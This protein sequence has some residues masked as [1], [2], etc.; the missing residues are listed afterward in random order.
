MFTSRTVRALGVLVGLSFVIPAVALDPPVVA[1]ARSCTGWQSTLLPPDTIRVFRKATGVVEVVPFKEYVVTVTAKEWPGWLPDAVIEAG[2]VA[3]K[4]YAW[5]HAMEGRHRGHNVTKSGECFDVR[6]TTADQLYKPAKAR[7]VQRHYAAVDKTWDMT[8]RKQ[9]KQFMTGYRTGRKGDCANDA[10]GWKLFARSA[11]KCANIEG[12]DW[13]R[14]LQAYYSPELQFVRSDGTIVDVD[15]FAI[16]HAAVIG[17]TLTANGRT[18]IFDERHDAINWQGDWRRTRSKPAHNKTLTYSSGRAASAVFQ[19]AGRSLDIVGRTGPNRGR[20][21]VYVDGE[22][23]KIVD[24]WAPSRRH[25]Q[26]IFSATWTDAA[27]RTIQLELDGP[28]G[29][30]RVDID[31]IAVTP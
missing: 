3:V 27:V 29:R 18:T 12:H 17:S 11:I 23:W 9:H 15:G 8:L 14:I 26:V 7:I 24:T 19:V 22:L 1:A 13:L 5:Y 31:A 21:R 10:N 16:G 30:P 20:L 4:Q 2:T 25:Q 6:D 28:V